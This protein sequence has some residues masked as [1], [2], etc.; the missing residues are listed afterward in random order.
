MNSAP[1]YIRYV[2]FKDAE[3]VLDWENN[4]ENWA[5]SE[6]DS[7]YSIYDVL[8]LIGELQDIRKVNQARW[9]ICLS[10][11]NKAIGNVD[12]TEIEFDKHESTV[13]ILIA[14]VI[15]RNKGY[16]SLALELIER[17]A[18]ELEINKLNCSI[19]SDNTASISLFEK[20]GFIKIGK[21]EKPAVKDGQN[22]DVLLFEKWL[23]K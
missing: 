15:Q 18:E 16:A 3:L 1:I 8:V 17:Q 7:P 23:K 6:N 2:E 22:I 4:Q 13:G 10:G 9:M 21:L 12:L 20:N 14:D 19:H 11:S 5:V